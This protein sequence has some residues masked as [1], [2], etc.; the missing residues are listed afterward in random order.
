MA[1][2][3]RIKRG[4]THNSRKK[5][6]FGVAGMAFAKKPADESLFKPTRQEFFRCCLVKEG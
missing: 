2:P 4:Q 6:P 5:S 1:L 3:T